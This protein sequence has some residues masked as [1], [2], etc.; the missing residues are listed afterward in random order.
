MKDFKPLATKGLVVWLHKRLVQLV[1]DAKGMRAEKVVLE[2]SEIA[3]K[4][5]ESKAAIQTGK[6]TLALSEAGT[7]LYQAEDVSFGEVDSLLD[8]VS[9]VGGKVPASVLAALKMKAG[10][11]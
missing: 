1:E 7:L 11:K 8:K 3:A 10:C 9:K 2:G 4:L 6:D 5:S